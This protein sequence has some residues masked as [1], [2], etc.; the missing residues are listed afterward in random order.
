MDV[1]HLRTLPSIPWN[2][3]TEPKIEEWLVHEA[4]A[5]ANAAAHIFSYD[6]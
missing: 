6:V 5:V 3:V 1:E 4:D 2:P